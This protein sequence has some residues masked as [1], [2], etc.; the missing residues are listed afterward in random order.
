VNAFP[1]S[2]CTG[3]Y[4]SFLFCLIVVPVVLCIVW[5]RDGLYFNLFDESLIKIGCLYLQSV[6]S[7]SVYLLIS[8]GP[9]C[10]RNPWQVNTY[11]V[12]TRSLLI[13]ISR[14]WK[15]QGV[16]HCL[17][18]PKY[19]TELLD[20]DCLPGW[21]AFLAWVIHLE[22]TPVCCLDSCSHGGSWYW[23]CGRSSSPPTHVPQLLCG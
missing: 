8:Q 22:L 12:T 13:V 2:L 21:V 23:M 20:S 5:H 6:W 11:T 18:Q 16:F 17:L 19:R 15:G 7:C 10:G 3:E 4:F 9:L 14:R 1:S